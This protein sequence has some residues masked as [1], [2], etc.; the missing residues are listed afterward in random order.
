MQ[1]IRITGRL[2]WQRQTAICIMISTSCSAELF[3]Q[4]FG[5]NVGKTRHCYNNKA[6][7]FN[8]L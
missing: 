1:G 5:K 7:Y 8:I 3:I 6:T 2:S 4:L